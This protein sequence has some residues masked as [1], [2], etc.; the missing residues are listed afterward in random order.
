MTAAGSP[1][2]RRAVLA[3]AVPVVS[4]ALVVSTALAGC[5]APAGGGSGS[6]AP[7]R[8]AALKGPTGM[9]LVQ[10]MEEQAGREHPAYS[11]ALYDAPDTLLAKVINAEY[12]VAALPTNSAAIIYAKTGG[13]VQ[14]AA[15][16]TLGV[17]SLLERGERVHALADLRG[18]TVLASGKGSTADVVFRYVVS[19]AGLQVGRDVTVSFVG[20][21][22]DVATAAAAGDAPLALLPQPFATVALTKN[23]ALRVAVDLTAAWEQVQGSGQRLPMGCL[24]VNTAYAAAHP[25]RVRDF[26]AAFRA[27]VAYTNGQP[28]RAGELIAKHGIVAEA[29]VAAAAIPASHLVAVDAAEAEAY[30]APF[31]AA[32]ASFDPASVGGTV[33]DDRFYYRP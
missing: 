13:A 24:V 3:A 9:G 8:V 11:F 30:V 1:R 4:V 18:T 2:G 26:L 15:V 25:D 19:K 28:H 33:P 21:H 6:A 5:A 16:N 20:A 31:L 22:A 29:Q 27:S 17:V 32:L 23:P 10:L 12:D 14:L 7:L